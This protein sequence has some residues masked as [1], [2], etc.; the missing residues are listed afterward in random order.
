MSRLKNISRFLLGALAV[1]A[2]ASTIG[3]APAASA[4]AIMLPMESCTGPT[5]PRT[6]VRNPRN[7]CHPTSWV[8]MGRSTGR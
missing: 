8:R 6:P 5:Y 3:L 4:K 2:A 1:A 7:R